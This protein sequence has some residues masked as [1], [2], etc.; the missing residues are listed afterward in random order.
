MASGETERHRRLKALA[1]EWAQTHGFPIAGLEVRV[2]HSGYR[3]DVAACGR[4][5]APLTALFECKQSRADL[6]RD[7]HRLE[8]TRARLVELTE[9]RV[10]LEALLSVHRPDL[11]R[12]E[13]LFP[14]YDAWDFSSVEHRPYRDLLAELVTLQARVRGGT[15]FSRMFRYR[16]ADLLYLVVE[17]D[18][19]A[20]AEV[21]AGWG[22]LVRDDDALRLAKPPVTLDSPPEQRRALL[23]SIAISG[24]RA[25]NRLAG[26][27]LRTPPGA[28]SF[29]PRDAVGVP[30][31]G[32]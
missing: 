9:R 21:P 19:H 32:A 30:V 3:A 18:L 11:R 2:P 7:A 15:K 29:G 17:D 12:G 14:E 22:V 13:S 23:E 20:P 26:V 6:L 10:R 24:T 27:A 25:T 16:S 8:E 1:L 5:K 31:A 28:P 4:G